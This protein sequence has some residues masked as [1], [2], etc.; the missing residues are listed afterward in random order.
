MTNDELQHLLL[1]EQ[2]S[3]EGEH[4][5]PTATAQ[6]S[7]LTGE[8]SASQNQP[9]GTDTATL[10]ADLFNL[11]SGPVYTALETEADRSQAELARRDLYEFIRAA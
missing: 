9:T 11:P 5:T 1:S 4:S 10:L 6:D 2:N 7:S 8:P 3:I